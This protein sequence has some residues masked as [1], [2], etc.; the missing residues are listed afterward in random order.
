MNMTNKKRSKTKRSSREMVFS[1]LRERIVDGHYPQGGK[2]VETD[3]ACEFKV[4][5]LMIREVFRELESIGLVEKRLNRGTLVRR[6]D[7]E[8][9]F[10]IMD[11]RE[12][13]EGLAARLAAQKSRPED[14]LDLQREF[15]EPF[16]RIVRD[17]DFES[18]LDLITTFRE[19]MV[20]AAQNEDLSKL[21]NSLYAK[22]RI[23]QRRMIILPGRIQEAV[24][25]HRD[26]L[27]AI[28]EGNPEGAEKK[29][30]KNLRN[31]RAWLHKYKSWVL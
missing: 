6:V 13:L 9:L 27:K 20:A 3:L 18:Y 10:E 22:I 12:V 17:S 14:W 29:K 30:R 19:R 26:V 23:V 31:A 4:G 8:N 5:R 7:S 16:E 15:G 1:T 2:L 11:I 21:I 25:E 28:M 24:S